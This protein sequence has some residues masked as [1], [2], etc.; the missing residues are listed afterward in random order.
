M[1]SKMAS[2][3]AEAQVQAFTVPDMD[4][5]RQFAS[6]VDG[7]SVG[8]EL[9]FHVIDWSREQQVRYEE[10]GTW[11]LS[12]LELRLMIFAQQRIDRW[13][14]MTYH[15]CDHIVESLLAALRQAVEDEAV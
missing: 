1:T 9:G 13:S 7:Y 2:T 15:E 5:W 8:Q 4:E 14:G 11:D 3:V 12:V 6:L 10:T